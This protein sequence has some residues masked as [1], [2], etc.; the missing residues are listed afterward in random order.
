[1]K[2]LTL[3][4]VELVAGGDLASDVISQAQTALNAS[5]GLVTHN[6]KLVVGFT[7]SATNQVINTVNDDID[8]ITNP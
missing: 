7:T 8:F 6:Y 4:D 2:E 1:M 3:N 5:G